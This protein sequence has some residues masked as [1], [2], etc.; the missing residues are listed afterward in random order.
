MKAIDQ[1][2]SFQVALDQG[3]VAVVIFR[4]NNVEGLH[5]HHFASV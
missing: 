1:T 4:E 2:G 5:C 3:G